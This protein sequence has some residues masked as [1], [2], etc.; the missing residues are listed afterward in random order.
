M[1]TIDFQAVPCKSPAEAL[2][3]A[4]TRGGVAVELNGASLVLIDESV[5]ATLRR[6]GAGV[7]RIPANGSTAIKASKAR[8]CRMS[9]TPPN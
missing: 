3:R 1:F 7:H 8:P 6:F 2:H 4:R 9:W 5:I